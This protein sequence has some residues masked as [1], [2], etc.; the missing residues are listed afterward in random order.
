MNRRIMILGLLAVGTAPPALAQETPAPAAPWS[1]LDTVEISLERAVAMAEG[2]GLQARGALATWEAARQRNRVFYAQQLPQFGLTATAPSYNRA[3]IPV[4]QPDGTTLFQPQDETSAR[5]DATVT[6]RVPLIGG[7]LSFVSSLSRLSRSGESAFESWT[8]T[9]FSISFRQDLLRPN[10]L[11]WDR[12]EQPLRLEAAERAYLEAREDVAISV[13]GFFFDLHAA[14]VNLANQVANAATNDTLYTLNKGRFE[15]G[16]IGENDLLQSELALLRA[17]NSLDAARLEADRAEAALRIAVGLPASAPVAI[18]VTGDVPAVDADTAVAVAE[19]LRNR[20]SVSEVALQEVQ[21]NRR[22]TEA[23]LSNWAGAALT[24]SYGF[25]ATGPERRLAYANLLEARQF[26]LALQLPLWQWG[27][28]AGTVAAAKADLERAESQAELSRLQLIQEAHFA[29]LGLDQARRTLVIA[30]KADTVAGKRFE[31]ALNRYII[32]R[33]QL[34]NLFVAQ[35][36]KDQALAASVQ[37]LRGY[38][39]AYFRLRRST[40]YDFVAK[41]PLQ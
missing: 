33:I 12:R 40:L 34:D 41:T 35:S 18:R 25:N 21:A 19:A 38:W 26:S 10:S 1:A 32:G 31:V 13:T 20:A 11:G 28:H 2:K 7:D 17:R 30:S 9:P 37:A 23:R 27:A 8:S 15:V 5:V 39:L 3:I 14:R 4:L 22:V 36:E 29:A 16:K 24:A 6:Q